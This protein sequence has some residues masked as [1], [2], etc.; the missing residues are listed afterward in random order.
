MDKQRTS[1]KQ[2]PSRQEPTLQSIHEAQPSNIQTAARAYQTRKQRGT[3]PMEDTPL[4]ERL[5]LLGPSQQQVT[6]TLAMPAPLD[7]SQDF[8]DSLAPAFGTNFDDITIVTGSSAAK[9]KSAPAFAEN[10]TIHFGKSVLEES[11]KI[12]LAHELVHMM[13]KKNTS[14]VS[15]TTDELEEEAHFLGA[16]AAGG[17]SIAGMVKGYAPRSQRQ[18]FDENEHAMLGNK[19]AALA[20]EGKSVE[21]DARVITLAPDYALSFGEVTFM[22]GDYFES[23]EQMQRFARNSKH[24]GIGTRE[25]LEYIRKVKR[26]RN[27]PKKGEFTKGIKEA[28]DNRFY[29]LS[30]SNK[31]H[32]TSP[33]GDEIECEQSAHSM[34]GDRTKAANSSAS[35]AACPLPKDGNRST[36]V[37]IHE[38]A[39]MEAIDAGH[40]QRVDTNTKK[41]MIG[42]VTLQ[43][44]FA[45]EAAASHYLTDAFASGHI[46]THR[47][48]ITDY[49]NKKVPMFKTNLAGW[50]AETMARNI[51]LPEWYK[52]ILATTEAK[53]KGTEKDVGSLETVTEVINNKPATLGDLVSGAFHDVDNHNGLVAM[54]N[55]EQKLYF[56]DGMLQNSSSMPA[57]DKMTIEKQQQDIAQAVAIGVK[58]VRRAYS[59]AKKGLAQHEILAEVR[60]EEGSYSVEKLWPTSLEPDIDYKKAT[61]E[62]LFSDP[63]FQEGIQLLVKEKMQAFASSVPKEHSTAFKEH[64][65]KPLKENPIAVLQTVVHW[66][67]NTR[68]GYL[69]RNQDDNA[70]DYVHKAE[71]VPGGLCSL[72]DKQRSKLKKDIERHTIDEIYPPARILSEP[73]RE[74]SALNK[75]KETK[76]CKP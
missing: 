34:K 67:P 46:R 29:A 49:W 10:H 8:V 65:Q 69:G 26:K 36:Y 12:I 63:V 7:M 37:R 71:M 68:G 21:L 5:H 64:I 31:A 53:Y 15:M 76:D 66:T 22:S 23:I 61:T 6:E 4:E 30:I 33:H 73:R 58:D 17:Q 27:I 52:E 9:A 1:S 48:A 20:S 56:G 60:S 57:E 40:N 14:G 11:D 51:V 62:E 74:D 59:L 43:D 32:F 42:D 24:K 47:A 18:F 25:E 2:Q 72:T 16:M 54:Q 55:G 13:Q 39:I 75:L 45:T 44:A 19:G 50:M 41:T 3:S 35:N 38:Q 70:A 28:V